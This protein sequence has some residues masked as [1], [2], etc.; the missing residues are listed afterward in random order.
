MDALKNLMKINRFI[1]T[2]LTFCFVL[3]ALISCKDDPLTQ[4]IDGKPLTN[5]TDTKWKLIGFADNL[6]NNVIEP[7]AELQSTKNALII[8]FKENNIIEGYGSSESL[9][10]YGKFVVD[11]S[12]KI[13]K[14]I[15]LWQ[16]TLVLEHKDVQKF[17]EA[18]NKVITYSI[19]AENLKLFYEDGKKYLFF[20]RI[21]N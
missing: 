2:G 3:I 20:K 16:M 17:I 5:L 19:S 14:S 7:A 11:S 8:E 21:L 1:F 10:L 13:F 18:T 4:D 6:T 9:P 15:Q 12:L